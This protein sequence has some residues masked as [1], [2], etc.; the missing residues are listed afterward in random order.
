ML[1]VVSVAPSWLGETQASAA[2]LK[3]CPHG[4]AY[5][6]IADAVNAAVAGDRVSVAGGVYDGGF[7]INKN[8]TLSGAGA[9]R[10]TVKG[11]GPVVT[12]GAYGATSEPTVVIEDVTITGGVTRSSPDGSFVALGGGVSVPPA[13]NHGPGAT[14]AIVRSIISDN[15]ATP[16]TAVDAGFSCGAAD[17]MFAHAGG[18]GI[19]SW[20]NL[21]LR[22]SVVADNRAAGSVTSDANGAGIYAQQG[23]LVV[24]HSLVIGNRAVA[25]VP[26]G[27][28]AEG[29]GVMFDT[30]FS[31]PGT[32]SA[33]QPTCRLIVRASAVIGNVS[34]LTSAL[35]SFAAGQLIGMNANAGGIHVGDNIP[36]TVQNTAI[37]RNSAIA[38]D[39]QG[40]PNAIDAGMIIGDS[41][42][43][44]HNTLVDHNLTKVTSATTTDSG[45][46]GSALELDGPGT[47][48]NTSISGNVA[49]TVTPNGDAGTNGGLAVFNF[50]GDPKLVTVRDSVVRRNVT[51]ARS[52]TGSATVMGGGV[53]NNSLLLMH[54]VLVGSNV[55]R[56]DGPSGVAQGGGIWNGVD[57]S[58]PPVQLTLDHSSLT[59]NV[60]SGGPGITAQGGGLFT[61]TPVTLTKTQIALNRPDQC[62]GCSLTAQPIASTGPG[63][64]PPTTGGRIRRRYTARP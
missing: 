60:L 54:D 39:P 15:L 44:M 47:I 29:A 37:N 1:S 50:S 53:F 62:V 33:P 27:R 14:V 24:D 23:S 12:V 11:G 7:T 38:R 25:A 21:T 4:C 42:L 64:A 26:D 19:D 8:L 5:A 35:P 63:L 32:C 59:R 36:T 57:L 41:P 56:A 3:V 34:T 28:F 45:P 43:V 61:N 58:G 48:D 10:T 49:T 55:A 51:T 9:R 22:E 16:A 6:Q 46:S 40:E 31:P 13:A 17:C 30:F 20:G 2:T 18:G 52:S